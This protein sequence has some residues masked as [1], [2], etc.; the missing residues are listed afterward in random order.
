MF[1]NTACF[2]LP[3]VLIATQ[4]PTLSPTLLDLCSMSIIHRFS[5]PA[6]FASIKDHLGAASKMVSTTEHQNDMFKRIL[7]LD[8]GES[9]VFAP[10][11]FVGV[12]G[13]GEVVKLGAEALRMKTRV[14]TGSDGGVSRL[15]GAGDGGGDVEGISAKVRDVL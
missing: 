7:N 11:A 6:W 10:S 8:V 12:R 3:Q 15:A 14:R 1:T 4:E 9:L 2:L 13:C 5:S